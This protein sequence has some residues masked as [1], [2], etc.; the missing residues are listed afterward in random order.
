MYGETREPIAWDR[1]L[2]QVVRDFAKD[3]KIKITPL[4]GDWIF[5]LEKNNE[6]HFIFG[7]DL[8]LNNSA[9][10]LLARDKS[11]TSEILASENIP[12]I[13]HELF[14]R[15]N[16][17]GSNPNGNWQEILRLF[18][19][20]NKDLVLKPNIGSSGRS[21][22]RAKNTAELEAAVQKIFASERTLAL[23]PYVE[24]LAEYR[25]TILNGEMLNIYKKVKSD[26]DD[27]KFNLGSGAYAENIDDERKKQ[28]IQKLAESAAN[29]LN[30]RFT[31][32]DV[33]ESKNALEILEINSGVMFEHFAKQGELEKEKAR[34]IYH[35]ALTELFKHVK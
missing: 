9:S 31:N 30:I 1:F 15:P 12:H 3:K 11:A 18:D 10:K 27:L 23:S 29:A 19:Y 7:L 4:S 5:K 17:L 13:P 24:M 16:S 8:G 14:L 6:K 21:V 32:I 2:A 28:E 20:Y 35:K 22:I 33:S 26:P 34:S 25:V